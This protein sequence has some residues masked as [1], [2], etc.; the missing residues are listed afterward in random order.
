MTALSPRDRRALLWGVGTPLLAVLLL[1]GVPKAVAGVRHLRERAAEQQ[2]TLVRVETVIVRGPA[3][4]DS[5]RQVVQ[6]IVALAPAL[7][8]GETVADAQSSLS[9]LLSL[10]ANRHGL[11]VIRMDALPDSTAGVFGRVAVHAEF[12]GD[13]AGVTGF[14][15]G[16][17]TGEPLLSLANLA[18]DT[19]DPVP[20]PRTSEVLHLVVDV[21]GY[22]LPR[23]N[24]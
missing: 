1:R 19:P 16:L 12:E 20:H 23:R 9:A 24:P 10:A 18:L 7:V 2:A 8:D 13:L 22:Y 11:K 14:V 3:V 15:G 5:L 17:E 21:R 6:G 4:R